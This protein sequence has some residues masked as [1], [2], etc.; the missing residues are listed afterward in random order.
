L[1]SNCKRFQLPNFVDRLRKPAGFI[2]NFLSYHTSGLTLDLRQEVASNQV[3]ISYIH[4]GS[5]IGLD[6]SG[7]RR[8]KLT[9]RL[10]ILVA[11]VIR[12]EFRHPLEELP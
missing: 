11:F 1:F 9:G 2:L 4:G 8:Y 3:D 6:R 10:V 5:Q 7:K 12:P